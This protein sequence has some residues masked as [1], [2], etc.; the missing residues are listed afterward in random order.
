M[1]KKGSDYME[2]GKWEKKLQEGEKY[3]R[4]FYW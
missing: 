1:C 2:E 4:E 3:A